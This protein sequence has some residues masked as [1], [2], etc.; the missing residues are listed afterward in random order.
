MVLTVPNSKDLLAA[1][2]RPVDHLSA[3]DYGDALKRAEAGVPTVLTGMPETTFHLRQHLD[4]M[5][6]RASKAFSPLA[7]DADL[8]SRVSARLVHRVARD[9]WEVQKGR[10]NDVR[11]SLRTYAALPRSPP[12]SQRLSV[13]QAVQVSR[14][15]PGRRRASRPSPGS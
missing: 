12:P 13:P 2:C 8:Y 15:V 4:D 10:W 6:D 7:I 14:A 11:P 9:H 5:F 1:G 3:L